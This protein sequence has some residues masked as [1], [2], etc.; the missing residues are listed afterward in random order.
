MNPRSRRR[1]R[2]SLVA[3]PAFGLVALQVPAAAAEQEQGAFRQTN[4]VSNVPGL[5]QHTDSHLVNPW[6]ISASPTSPFWVAD[7]GTGVTTVYANGSPVIIGPP[8]NRHQLVVTV[9]P[10]SDMPALTSAPTGTVFNGTSDFELAAGQPA[11]FLF[12]TEDGTISGWNPNV[13]AEHAVL[14]VD[15]SHANAVYKGLALGSSAQGNFLYA[16]NF[17]AGVVEMFDRNFA[18][19]GSFTDP[20]V[21]PGFAPFNVENL[22]GL[23]WVTFAKQNAEKH[24]DVA[25]PGNGFVDVF[26]TSGALLRRFA[27]HGSL[28]SPWGLAIAPEDFGPFSGSLLV[29]N[30]GDGTINAFNLRNGKVKG[31]LR[32]TTGTPIVIDGLWGLRFGNGGA[33][34]PMHTLFF[35]A[36]INHEQDGLYG[37]I[38]SMDD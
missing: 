1:L 25:G 34:G 21:D 37:S 8:Q 13:N 20:K 31:H 36:G 4:L 27:K 17:H 32:D 22:R 26:S 9:P 7:N 12:A 15:H 23:L 6:G 24:D 5:A 11:R 29:G 2:I 30:F 10:P 19:A 35:T 16:A 14:K 33:G 18:P 38:V 28:N 3:I